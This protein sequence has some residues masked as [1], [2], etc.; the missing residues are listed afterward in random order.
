MSDLASEEKLAEILQPSSQAKEFKITIVF[1]VKAAS[2][3]ERAV[4][5]AHRNPTYAEEG[6]GEW[7]RHSATYTPAEVEDL[8]DLFNLVYA[9]D[10]TEVLVNN[11]NL[12]FGSSLWLPLMWF[13]RIK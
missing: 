12:P 13:Y 5:L 6:S 4:A 11:R 3:Y 7:V 2:N 9:W 8:F 10:D 1:G